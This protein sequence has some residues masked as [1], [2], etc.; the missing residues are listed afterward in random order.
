[1]WVGLYGAPTVVQVRATT[2]GVLK[3]VTVSYPVYAIAATEHAVWAVHNLP[4]ADASTD[5]PPGVVTRIAY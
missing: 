5:P 3:R 4:S 1:V 2:N